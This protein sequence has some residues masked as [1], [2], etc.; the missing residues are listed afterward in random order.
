MFIL[1]ILAVLFFG[2]YF[3][4]FITAIAVRISSEEKTFVK[5]SR[6]DSC[7]VRISMLH[8]VPIVGYI[9]CNKKCAHCKQKISPEYTIWEA[10][11]ATLWCVNFLFLHQS[12]YLF[13]VVSAITS[14]LVLISIID[15]KTMYIYDIHIV[16][17]FIL[18]LLFFWQKGV[19]EINATSF[20][21]ACL[22]LVFKLL[23]ER[24]RFV[25]TRQKLVVLGM[26]DVKLLCVLFFFLD[27]FNIAMI[28]CI[29][30]IVG[31]LFFC[32]KKRRD[33]KSYYPF[34]PAIAVGIYY[35]LLFL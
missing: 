16:F 25:F 6:C 13:I 8:L 26:G 4:S 21:K 28:M 19:L 9:I 30:G 18:F 20:V 24:L 10:I 2:L 29:S 31:M 22:P 11:H 23:Y 14:L 27:F 17:L 35:F 3:G 34:V 15:I 1:Y 5:H 7:G 32:A 33:A 12:M